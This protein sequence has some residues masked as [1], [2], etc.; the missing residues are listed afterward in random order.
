MSVLLDMKNRGVKDVFFLV[1]D[2][3]KGLPAVVANVWPLAIVQTSSVH[4]PRGGM[5]PPVTAP[6][7]EDLCRRA[8]FEALMQTC[9]SR[10]GRAA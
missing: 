10:W 3:L 4:T 9:P 7:G 2:G 6:P 5:V 8:A 1:C